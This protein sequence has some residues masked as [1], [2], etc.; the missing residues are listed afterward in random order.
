MFI[1]ASCGLGLLAADPFRIRTVYAE[2]QLTEKD[3]TPPVRKD[4]PV[5]KKEEVKK[6]G[7]GADRVWVTYKGVRFFAAYGRALPTVSV[8]SFNC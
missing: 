8:A 5:F 6:H 7:K 4:L 3:L 1:A 2:A